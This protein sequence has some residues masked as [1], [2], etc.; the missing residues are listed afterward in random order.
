MVVAGGQVSPRTEL[1]PELYQT[2]CGGALA[3]YLYS[4]FVKR[5]SVSVQDM[6]PLPL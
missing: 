4:R 3:Q 6:P 1:Q 2:M 5:L